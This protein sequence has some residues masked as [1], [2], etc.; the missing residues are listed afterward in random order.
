MNYNYEPEIEESN[1]GLLTVAGIFALAIGVVFAYIGLD[2]LTNG[3]LTARWNGDVYDAEEIE[4][5][6]DGDSQSARLQSVSN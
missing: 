6:I 3:K 1:T 2:L 4:T 5:E